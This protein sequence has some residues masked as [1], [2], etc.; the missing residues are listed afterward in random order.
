LCGAKNRW[1]FSRYTND[2]PLSAVVP[3]AANGAK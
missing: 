2:K 3:E 1:M